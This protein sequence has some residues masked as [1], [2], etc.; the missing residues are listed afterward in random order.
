MV[1][2]PL[3]GVAAIIG[4]NALKGYDLYM[5]A[6]RGSEAPQS[7]LTME[8]FASLIPFVASFF[9]MLFDLFGGRCTVS[10]GGGET[11]TWSI[12]MN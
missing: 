11:G 1:V 3:V 9:E 4:G 6:Q 7:A 12:P 10:G 5:T 2:I 8:F